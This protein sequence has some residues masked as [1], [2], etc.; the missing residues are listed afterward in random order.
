MAG[1]SIQD[2]ANTVV[3]TGHVMSPKAWLTWGE[4]VD[5]MPEEDREAFM[6]AAEEASAFYSETLKGEDERLRKEFEAKGIEFVE[7]GK[8]KDEMREI[9]RKS[10]RM[11]SSH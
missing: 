5:D 3:M 10:T 8:S 1:F 7:P 6:R 11:N 2:V 9:D 4:W